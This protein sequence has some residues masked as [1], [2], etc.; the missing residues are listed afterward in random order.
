MLKAT[1][2][3][4]KKIEEKSKNDKAGIVNEEAPELLGTDYDAMK[5][6]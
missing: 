2:Q 4:L 1:N 5:R 6:I 3:I